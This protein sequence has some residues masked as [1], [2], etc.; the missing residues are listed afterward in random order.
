MINYGRVVEVMVANMMFSLDK[1]TME[2]S[3][4]FDNDMLPNESEIKIWNLSQDTINR[5]K[6]NMTLMVNAGYRGDVGLILH[7]YIS[8]VTTTREGPDRVT[9]IYVLDSEDLSKREIREKSYAAGTL[10]SYILKD[11]TKEI[12][13]PVGQF[14]LNMD[15]KYAEGYTAKGSAI[16]IC[17]KVASDCG[18]SAYINKGKLYVRSL[19]RGKDDAFRLS[20]ETGLIGSPEYFEEEGAKG[21]KLRSQLQYRI[22]TAS[23]IEMHAESFQGRV[24]AR[25]GTHSFSNANDFITE[26]EAVL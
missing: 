4:P 9:S 25:S 18:T 1:Y 21:Y 16:E 6:R 10:A 24:Y 12:G 20:P 22:T 3:I 15:V 14:D 17:A 11:M 19:R 26:V 8:K 7:G 13:L 23:L 5:I 2:G